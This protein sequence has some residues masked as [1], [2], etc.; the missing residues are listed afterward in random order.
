MSELDLARVTLLKVRQVQ[1]KADEVTLLALCLLVV[2]VLVLN[3]V[4]TILERDREVVELALVFGVGEHPVERDVGDGLFGSVLVP[5]DHI[6]SRLVRHHVRIKVFST[7]IL[8][9]EPLFVG[10]FEGAV[11][12]RHVLVHFQFV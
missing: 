9:Q 8:A 4:L 5:L 1:H 3:V 12:V 6:Q 11:E 10:H 7:I 2:D